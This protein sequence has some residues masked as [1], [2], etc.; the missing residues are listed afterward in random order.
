MS[1]INPIS[2]DAKKVIKKFAEAAKLHG[3]EEDQGVGNGPAKA[4]EKFN[5]RLHELEKFVAGLE[6]EIRTLK[7]DLV[8]AG[9]QN[10]EHSNV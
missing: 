6:M 1:N 2:K 4:E 8:L 3:W 7:V 10:K 5:K 9:S